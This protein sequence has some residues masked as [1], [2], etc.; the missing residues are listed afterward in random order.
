MSD[1]DDP[2]LEWIPMG[3]AERRIAVDYIRKTEG[4]TAAME[5]DRE[6]Q[7]AWVKE[8]RNGKVYSLADD[9]KNAKNRALLCSMTS[10]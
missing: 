4:P 10:A 9:M 8:Q 5:A 2:V 7:K 3:D 1:S 6:I